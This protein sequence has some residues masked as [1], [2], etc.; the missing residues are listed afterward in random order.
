MLP[1][2]VYTI[3]S[4]VILAIIG[5]IWSIGAC[6]QI[7]DPT[8]LPNLV[9]WLDA[10]DVNGNGNQPANGASLRRWIDKSGNDAFVGAIESEAPTF[11]AAGFDGINPGIRFAPGDRM[12][13][14]RPFPDRYEDAITVFFVNANVNI[15]A[16]VPLSLNGSDIGARRFSFHTPWSNNY[17]FFDAGGCCGSTR[18]SGPWPNGATETTLVMGLNDQPGSRQWL[19]IDGAAFRND[20][21]AI[22]TQVING[23]TFGTNSGVNYDGRFAEIVVY[24]RALSLSEVE[25]VECY[26]LL[27]WKPSATPSGCEAFP[28]L[29]AS[30]AVDVYAPFSTDMYAVPGSDVIFTLRVEHDSGAAVDSDSMFLVDTLPD[31]VSFYNGDVDGGGPEV[32]PVSWSESGSGLTFTYAADVAFSNLSARPSSM[33]D[34][35]YTPIPG[36]DPAVRHICL[37]PKGAFASSG[38][39][40]Y[41]EAQFRA[42]VE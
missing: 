1:C 19:R 25:A 4:L 3:R 26:L 32:N 8:A 9:L 21:N 27:K 11:E 36:Y 23:V 38:A 20:N 10:T 35:T 18:L 24:A 28:E 31:E 33:A 34:C 22:I 13:G 6:A 12:A 15:T 42:R 39:T 17:V 16:S 40:A 5:S 30:K 7:T 2:S 29:I 41:F 37:N 14:P